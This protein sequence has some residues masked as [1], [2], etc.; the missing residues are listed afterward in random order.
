MLIVS[1][2]TERNVKSGPASITNILSQ[3]LF[4]CFAVAWQTIGSLKEE[5]TRSSLPPI[6]PPQCLTAL[7]FFFAW[8]FSWYRS[9]VQ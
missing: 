5:L 4:G 3:Q 1:P 8:Y 6:E 9:L 2:Q 7:G